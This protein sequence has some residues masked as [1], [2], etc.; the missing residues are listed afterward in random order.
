MKKV[1][2]RNKETN[3]IE[4]I[5]I[6]DEWYALIRLLEDELDEFRKSM[7]SNKIL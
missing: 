2:V 1:K 6:S 4:E 3:N 5:T 7:R